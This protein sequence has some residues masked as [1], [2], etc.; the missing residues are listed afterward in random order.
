MNK[1]ICDKKILSLDLFDLR[2]LLDLFPVYG[3]RL[4]DRHGYISYC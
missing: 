3:I 1:T 2:D 4:Y